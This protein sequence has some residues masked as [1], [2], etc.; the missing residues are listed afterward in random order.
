MGRQKCKH[1]PLNGKGNGVCPT[2]GAPLH[3]PRPKE[4]IARNTMKKCMREHCGFYGCSRCMAKDERSGWWYHLD[5][6]NCLRLQLERQKA[7]SE[8]GK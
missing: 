3:G 6:K 8:P 2:C 4:G 1:K 7:G 5:I